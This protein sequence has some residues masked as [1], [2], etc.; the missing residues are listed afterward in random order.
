M[1]LTYVSDPVNH[2]FDCTKKAEL[3]IRREP[4]FK[5]DFV[6]TQQRCRDF[7]VAILNVC[8]NSREV[9][10]VLDDSIQ[11]NLFTQ[12]MVTLSFRVP[13]FMVLQGR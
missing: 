12:I 10:M 7:A 9:E 6:E 13:F 4:E 8:R 3:G 11:G 1:A 5:Q 2:A